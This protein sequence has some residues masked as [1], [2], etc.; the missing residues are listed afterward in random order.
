M[1]YSGNVALGYIFPKTHI[2]CLWTPKNL[3][4]PPPCLTSTNNSPIADNVCFLFNFF[5]LKKVL[6]N[7]FEGIG[8]EGFFFG[9]SPQKWWQCWNLQQMVW[10]SPN[11]FPGKKTSFQKN[12]Q[13][14]TWKSGHSVY[15]YPME[16][17]FCQRPR[18]IFDLFGKPLS[19]LSLCIL[20]QVSFVSN[21][22]R[23]LPF[24]FWKTRVLFCFKNIKKRQLWIPHLFPT[25]NK[26]MQLF[27]PVLLSAPSSEKNGPETR[28]FEERIGVHS[29]R[30]NTMHEKSSNVTSRE[31]SIFFNIG[32]I[33]P[34]CPHEWFEF[35]GIPPNITS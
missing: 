27:K 20:G 29:K 31:S 17:L 15:L 7:T 22:P 32:F 23:F 16:I 33:F 14:I 9:V 18:D 8:M 2:S 24:F 5:L 10:I 6:K 1:H 25:D 12:T 3:L 34:P 4:C 19:F 11:Y 30:E 13:N 26:T 35:Q 28:I 21:S